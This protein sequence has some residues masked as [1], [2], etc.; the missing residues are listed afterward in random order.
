MR[1]LALPVYLRMRAKVVQEG[2]GGGP[3]S[4]SWPT[5][6]Q[7]PA[8]RAVISSSIA[9]PEQFLTVTRTPC[10]PTDGKG[11]TISTPD[12]VHG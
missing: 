1:L 3:A 7:L 5:A 2:D 4:Q 11:W 12:S 6:V 9:L 10:V 8:A